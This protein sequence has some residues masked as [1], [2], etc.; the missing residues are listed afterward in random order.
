M[1]TSTNATRSVAEN[2]VVIKAQDDKESQSNVPEA[3][4][5]E[6][7]EKAVNEH[8]AD[9]LIAQLTTLAQKYR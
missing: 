7:V 8:G 1:A 5:F 6:D 3:V 2:F 9:N 4:F